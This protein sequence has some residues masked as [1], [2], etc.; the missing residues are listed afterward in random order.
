MK[1][2]HIWIYFKNKKA[3]IEKLGELNS[4]ERKEWYLYLQQILYVVNPYIRRK[5]F[6][7][8]PKPDFF[9]ALELRNI[10]L[11]KT[12]KLFLKQIIPIKKPSFVRKIVFK[13][14]M[15]DYNNGEGFL[16]IMNDVTDYLLFYR[17]HPSE[18]SHIIHCI[19]NSWLVNRWNEYSLNKKI[20]E[21]IIKELDE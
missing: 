4:K 14:N 11:E 13:P 16:N 5:F 12:F 2:Y 21:N 20:C 15:P 1:W 6:L 9:L 7:Y 3:I 18:M 19:T 10:T 8:E 17:D